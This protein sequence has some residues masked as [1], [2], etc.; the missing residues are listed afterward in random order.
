MFM[1][2]KTYQENAMNSKSQNFSKLINSEFVK[3]TVPSDNKHFCK[4]EWEL[5]T[6]IKPCVLKLSNSNFWNIFIYKIYSFL[7]ARSNTN[8]PC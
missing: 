7:R 4:L 3:L 1:K 2:R 5:I 8:G 6:H